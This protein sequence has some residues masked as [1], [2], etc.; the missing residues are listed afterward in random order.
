ME[1]YEEPVERYEMPDPP[2]PTSSRTGLGGERPATGIGALIEA[3]GTPHTHAPRLDPE[4][5][6]A[7]LEN[8]RIDWEKYAQGWVGIVPGTIRP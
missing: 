8:A 7:Y 6:A 3:N 4:T 2:R 5:V 1:W